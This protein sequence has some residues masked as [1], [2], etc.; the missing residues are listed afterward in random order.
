MESKFQIKK[1]SQALIFHFTELTN[2]V[3]NNLLEQ[4]LSR[5]CPAETEHLTAP[6][7]QATML[8]IKYETMGTIWFG[9]QDLLRKGKN[10]Q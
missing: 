1:Q 6:S 10:G 3:I 9:E 5:L 7:V 4:I 2:V 8:P